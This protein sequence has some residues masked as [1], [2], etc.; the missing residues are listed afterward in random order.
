ME[1]IGSVAGEIMAIFVTAIL[2]GLAHMG[3]GGYYPVVLPML[4]GL[5]LG[6]VV[7]KTKN[8]YSSI[9]AHILFNF[10]VFMLA[11][12]STSLK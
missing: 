5:V 1:K 3:Y 2:F 6:A 9:I 11:I 10:T 7:I 4:M 8:L 12:F